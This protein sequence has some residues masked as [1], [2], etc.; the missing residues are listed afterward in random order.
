MLVVTFSEDPGAK[1]NKGEYKFARAK[2]DPRRAMVPEFEAVAFALA[3]NQVSDVITTGF[4]YHIVKLHEL[5]PARKVPFTE[6]R[7]RIQDFFVQTALD[8]QMPAF[9]ALV[10]KDAEV[11]ITDEKL[12]AAMERAEKERASN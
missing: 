10:K 5:I 11:E 3:T 7:E 2:D 4:G 9:F 8:K 12:K 1:E 6:A